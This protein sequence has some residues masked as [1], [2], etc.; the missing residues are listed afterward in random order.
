MEVIDLSDSSSSCKDMPAAPILVHE[1]TAGGLIQ[2]DY[3]LICGGY[4]GGGLC[5]S[6]EGR[7]WQAT[8]VLKQAKF[9]LSFSPSPLSPNP[10]SLLIVG[11]RDSVGDISDLEQAST[12]YNWDQSLPRL[13]V[14]QAVGCMVKVNSTTVMV[15]GGYQNK[16]C[17][18]KTFY[19]SKNN[20]V[21]TEGPKL[22][23]P[24][25]CF[26]CA[27]I[28]YDKSGY[29]FTV[30]VAAGGY[31]GTRLSSS[32]VLDLNTGKWKPGPELPFGIGCAPLVEDA[33]GGVILVGGEAE[34]AGFQRLDKLFRLPH[35]GDG[36]KWTE[37]PQKLKTGRSR[38][39]AFLVPDNLT[40][41]N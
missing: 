40:N 20:K 30:I 1:G 5:H 33:G 22:L 10:H 4:T 28:R 18:D 39:I 26:G 35:A 6:Y 34:V 31:S 2:Q 25:C 17:S 16:A 13:P 19:F 37:L 7:S 11:G 23:I 41:C 12:S 27:R 14:T 24:R 29:L 38:H 8:A 21:W 3:L 36:S 9:Y 15:I 32:E